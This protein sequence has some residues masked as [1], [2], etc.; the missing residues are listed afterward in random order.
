MPMHRAADARRDSVEQ[1]GERI[2]HCSFSGST[3]DESG[4]LAQQ[5]PGFGPCSCCCLDLQTHTGTATEAAMA[6]AQSPARLLTSC[7]RVGPLLGRLKRRTARG[8]AVTQH[9]SLVTALGAVLVTPK[10]VCL[11]LTCM[12]WPPAVG[13]DE[14]FKV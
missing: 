7:L 8:Q 12:L 4:Q 6:P 14:D 11:C 5:Q 9:I 3:P 2:V 10:T 1:H 13:F